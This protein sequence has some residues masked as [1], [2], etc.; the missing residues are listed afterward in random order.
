MELWKDQ[1]LFTWIALFSTLREG[2]GDLQVE[3]T[4]GNETD[5]VALNDKRKSQFRENQPSPA[6]T[7]QTQLFWMWYLRGNLMIM[8]PRV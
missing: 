2:V 4:S 8:A 3:K 7:F 6:L 1:L 5:S